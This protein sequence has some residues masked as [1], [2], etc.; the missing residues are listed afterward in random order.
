[1]TSALYAIDDAGIAQMSH[2]M[3][4]SVGLSWPLLSS[5]STT[6]I[7]LKKNKVVTFT[8]VI[9]SCLLA[10]TIVGILRMNCNNS[11]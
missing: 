7:N 2:L 6:G 3:A 5:A 9:A 1:M 11:M 8:S 4:T 10:W